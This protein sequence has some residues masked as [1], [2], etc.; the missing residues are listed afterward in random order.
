MGRVHPEN[1]FRRLALDP[2]YMFF[3][4]SAAGRVGRAGHQA[5]AERSMAVDPSVIPLGALVW[6][7]VAPDRGPP[8]R[9]LMFA[10][11]T[12]PPIR[13]AR[14]DIFFGAGAQAEEVGGHL[15]ARG[16]RGCC[17]GRSGFLSKGFF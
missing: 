4:E 15:Y 7:D 14:A 3:R 10:E 2:S 12:G 1:G 17:G 13:G 8:L 9:R 16:G 6:I 11:D 5:G